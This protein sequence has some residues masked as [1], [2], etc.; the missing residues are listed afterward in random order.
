MNRDDFDAVER[1]VR[2]ALEWVPGDGRVFNPEGEPRGSR[3]LSLAEL[4]ARE[5]KAAIVAEREAC[6][7]LADTMHDDTIGDGVGRAIRARSARR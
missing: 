7:E 3:P 6:A 2:V 1:G 4:V 5:V